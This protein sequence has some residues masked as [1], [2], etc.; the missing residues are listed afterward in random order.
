MRH[1][2][3]ISSKTEDFN[4][5]RYILENMDIDLIDKSLNVA[6][7]SDDEEYIM[8]VIRRDYL[9]DSTV[10]IFLIG[11][12]SSDALGW[13]EQKYIKRELQGSLYH[14]T[15]NTQSGILG[16]VLPHMTDSVYRGSYACNRCGG[17][18]RYVNVKDTTISEFSYNYYIP[19]GDKCSWSEDDRFCVLVAWNEFAKAPEDYIH[20]AFNKR[21][22]PI[23]EKT[24]VYP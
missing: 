8:Q 17:S 11:S 2:C 20:K 18:H 22:H 21:G 15:G 14:G 7:D 12:Q 16:I 10:T 23:A 5:K 6:I 13:E 3:F 24:K 9:S 1:K 4:Y 19:N